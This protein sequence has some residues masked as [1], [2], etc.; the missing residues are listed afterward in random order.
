HDIGC[1]RW[2]VADPMVLDQAPVEVLDLVWRDAMA[3]VLAETRRHPVHRISTREHAFAPL[4][5]GG[6]TLHRLRLQLDPRPV[7]SDTHHLRERQ[8]LAVEDD[9]HRPS[10]GARRSVRSDRAIR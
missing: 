7:A 6:H 3:L 8:A 9:G 10:L 1:D 4:A 2:P 5:G